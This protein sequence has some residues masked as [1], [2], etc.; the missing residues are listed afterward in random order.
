MSKGPKSIATT[1]GINVKETRQAEATTAIYAVV[2]ESVEAIGPDLAPNLLTRH[3]ATIEL[4]TKKNNAAA[5]A[6]ATALETALNDENLAWSKDDR[7]WIDEEKIFQTVYN[8]N[9]LQK[10]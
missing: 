3:T 7:A 6:A 5:K 4:Y 1:A 10:G 9:Y 2:F 8:Y